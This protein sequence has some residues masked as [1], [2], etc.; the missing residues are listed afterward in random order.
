MALFQSLG[1]V[2]CHRGPNFSDASLLGGYAALRIFPT[3]P[4][5]V[6]ARYALTSDSGIAAPGQ[7]GVWRIPSLRNVALTGPYFHNG[8]VEK[9]SDAVRIMASAQLGIDVFSGSPSAPIPTVVW[10][11]GQR[12]IGSVSRRVIGDREVDDMVAFL[13]ALSSDALVTPARSRAH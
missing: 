8:S 4:G 2:E 7:P 9:L 3:F 1:C 6:E 12:Q 11:A 10:S 5:S 13:N